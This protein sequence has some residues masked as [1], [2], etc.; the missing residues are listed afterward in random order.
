[1][2]QNT[3]YFNNSTT[4]VSCTRK[5]EIIKTY[6]TSTPTQK[7]QKHNNEALGVLLAIDGFNLEEYIV[8]SISRSA[9]EREVARTEKSS[10]DNG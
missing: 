1:M 6:Q 7:H 9:A 5:S 3:N 2:T 10:I 8:S 4:D